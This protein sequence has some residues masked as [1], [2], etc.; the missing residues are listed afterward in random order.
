MP[1]KWHKYSYTAQRAERQTVVSIISLL[2][3]L[4]I[5]FSLINLYLVKMYVVGSSTM[6]PII[7][8]GDCVIT[9][10]LYK[11]NFGI[12]NKFSFLITPERGD[13][14]VVAPAYKNDRNTFQSIVDAI[15]SFISFQ[16]IRLFNQNETWGEKPFIRRLIA[17]PG[18]SIFMKDFVLHIKFKDAQHYL[19][20]F[21]TTNKNYDINLD[22][23]PANWT[24]ELPFSGSFDEITLKED[25]FYV[26]CD[27]RT[28]TSDSRIFGPIPAERIQGKV[29]FRY[30]P[31]KHFGQLE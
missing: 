14:I 19:S 18:D 31:F 12:A 15:V 26:L 21:E 3:C 16:R 5:V 22:F 10:P 17:F 11:K 30:W 6:T 4:Y 9:T 7:N 2:I 1:A 8:V 25:E 23:L 20:E 29:I 28:K 27:N 13:L 24:S